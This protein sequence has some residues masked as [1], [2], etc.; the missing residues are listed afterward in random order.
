MV[1]HLLKASMMYKLVRAYNYGRDLQY[2]K[3]AVLTIG[4]DKVWRHINIEHLSLTTWRAFM[5]FPLARGGFIYWVGKTVFLMM[6]VE[7]EIVSQ[8][9]IPA[10]CKKYQKS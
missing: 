9:P 5:S 3:C 1:K 7:T 8:L 2:V 4:I 10:L 6:N